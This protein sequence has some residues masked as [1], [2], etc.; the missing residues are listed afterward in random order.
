MHYLLMYDVVDDYVERRTPY[1]LEHIAL[2]REAVARGELVLGGALA[3]P[4]DGVVL[5]FRGSSPT[6]A[7]AFAKLD[8]YVRAGIV[9]RWRVREWTTVVGKEAENPTPQNLSRPGGV[10]KMAG[11]PWTRL[12]TGTARRYDVTL[13]EE[14]VMKK[15][16]GGAA[17]AAAFVLGFAARGAVPMEPVAHAQSGRGVELRTYTAPDGKL[18]ELHARFR[19]H[20][21]RI[22]KKHGIENVVYFAPQD[23]PLSQ[24]TLIYLVAH[25]SRE[26]AEKNWAEFQKD[27]EWQKV[28]N[29]S[30]V[31]GK[32]VAKV[33][34]IFLTPTDYS[35]MK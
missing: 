9:T 4:A 19:N 21:M 14:L 31:N 10:L 24:N 22:F 28:A 11:L 16:Y 3:Q 33:D 2:A 5:L 32:I 17:I 8:P 30:Q 29:E 25:P 26:A 20:T 7:E 27:P 35:P 1:R 13:N 34:R 23:A 18:A 6:A 12:R 15:L